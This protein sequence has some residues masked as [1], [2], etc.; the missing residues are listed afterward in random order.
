[1]LRRFD[2]DVRARAQ[3]PRWKKRGIDIRCEAFISDVEKRDDVLS[4]IT[5]NGETLEA[6]AYQILFASGATPTPAASGSWRPASQLDEAGAVIVD[7]LS[8]IQRAS[9]YAVGD[10]TNRS[11]NLTPVAIAER[12]R[13]RRDACSTAIDPTA[14]DHANVASAVFSQPPVGTVGFTEA[15]G[16]RALRRHRRL[17]HPS[18]RPMKHTLSGRDEQSMMKL[19]GGARRPARRGL[20]RRRR[21]RAR[22]RAGLRGGPPLRRD[23]GDVR[24]DDRDPPHRRRGAGDDAELQRPEPTVKND[25]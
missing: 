18:F 4:V 7:E 25:D 9:V 20:P 2:D 17:R 8:R 21:G 16:A 22:D 6:D 5:R 10:C 15:E 19:V 24:H 1:M 23:Q 3:P 12:P 14:I 13:R 11:S